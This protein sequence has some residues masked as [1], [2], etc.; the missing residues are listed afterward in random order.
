[1][2]AMAPEGI[3]EPIQQQLDDMKSQAEK[4][5]E[6]LDGHGYDVSQAPID[7]AIDDVSEEIENAAAN[8][9]QRT[10][11]REN[12][13]GQ[14]TDRPNTSAS[15]GAEADASLTAAERRL[16]HQL[17]RIQMVEAKNLQKILVETGRPATE[18]PIYRALDEIRA[19]LSRSGYPNV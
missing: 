15:A 7:M 14:D 8:D 19:A 1:M 5:S 6:A 9:V 2:D 4:L 12:Q 13:R 10:E 18:E 17:L 16:K 3:P 11:E